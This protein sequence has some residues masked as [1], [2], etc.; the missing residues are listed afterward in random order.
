MTTASRLLAILALAS[1]G[2]AACVAETATQEETVDDNNE[3]LSSSWK[4]DVSSLGSSRCQATIAEIR[5]QAAAAG[6]THIIERAI[7]WLQ[8]GNTYDRSRT[9]NGYRRD[10]SGFASMCWEFSA[11]PSTA[12]FPPFVSGTY[13]VALGSLDDLAPGDAVNKTYRNPYG[14]VMIFGGWASADHSQLYFLHHYSTGK[15]VGLIQ[16]SRSELGDYIPVR[17][18]HAPAPSETTTTAPPPPAADP[19]SGC[20]VLSAN[21]ALGVNQG[22]TSCDGRFTLIQQGDG[23]L[24]LYMAGHGALWSSGTYGTQGRTAVM[25][26]DGNFVVYTPAGQPV[27]HAHTNGHPGAFL[28]I[29]D[30]GNVVIYAGKAIWSTGTYG[31]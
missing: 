14:H 30:D 13:A 11:N 5:A 12:Y 3:A 24:V 23:N 29:Q 28:A 4:C 18:V 31:H 27:W 19:P 7:S 17:S 26:G 10:C 16:V 2:N 6:R 8:D 20:G 1:L 15:P 21:E 9:H 22:V 25:Q